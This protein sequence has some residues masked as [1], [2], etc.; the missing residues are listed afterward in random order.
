[1]LSALVSRLQEMALAQ[2]LAEALL[3]EAQLVLGYLSAVAPMLP[4][5]E[6]VYLLA[7][8]LTLLLAE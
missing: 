8:A 3:A 5:V 4:L 7:M 2:K 1:M 6:W